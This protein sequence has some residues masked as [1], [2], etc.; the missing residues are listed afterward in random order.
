MAK[1]TPRLFV[2]QKLEAKAEVTLAPEQSHYLANV[3]RLQPGDAAS[4][5]NG[6]DGEWLA[7][8]AEA[9][10]KK[11]VLRLEQLTSAAKPPPDIDYLFAPLKHAR[12]DYLVQKATELGARRLRP[13][14]TARTIAERVNLERMR[15]NVIE[16]AEQCNLVFVPEVLE[17]ISLNAALQGWDAGRALIYCDETAE[18]GDPLKALSKVTA[19]AAIVVGPEGGFTIEERAMLKALPFVTAVS[20]GPRIM[21]ADTAAVAILSVVQAAIGDWR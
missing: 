2:D 10:K 1:T 20:L 16:A 11:V 3:L 9:G 21:R 18:I 4:V 19:P 6:A 12:L 14:M 17:P 15:A 5:F 13:V 7:H 8:L